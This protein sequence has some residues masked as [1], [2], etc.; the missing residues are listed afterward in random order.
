MRKK[1]PKTHLLRFFQSR[2][3][4]QEYFFNTHLIIIDNVHLS[5]L[6]LTYF[7]K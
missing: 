5:F 1:Q 6:F 7:I 2:G 3:E 4:V